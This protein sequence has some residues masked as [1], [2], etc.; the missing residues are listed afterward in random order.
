MWPDNEADIDLLGF[1]YLVDELEIVLTE[2]R[3]LPVTV[4]VAGEWGSG[5]SSLMRLARARLESAEYGGRYVCVSFSPWRHEDAEDIKAALIATVMDALAV[6]LKEAEVAQPIRDRLERLRSWAHSWALPKTMA[7]TGALLAG[8]D[9]EVAEVAGAAAQAVGSIPFEPAA[10]PSQA[11]PRSFE[12]VSQF[13]VEFARLME[14]LRGEIDALVVFVDDLDRCLTPAIVST[15]EAIRLFL[16]APRTA[17]VVGAHQRIIQ[18]ALD[19]RYPRAGDR[20]EA[21]GIDYL[22]KVLQVTIAIPPLAAPEAL[23]YINLLF[24]ELYAD[25]AQ[26]D[27]LLTEALRIRAGDQLAEAM[28]Y[29][30]AV[31]VLGELPEDLVEAFELVERIG[32]P[33]AGGA[34]G[35]PRQ[36]KRFLNTLLLRQRTAS[37]RGAPIRP[38]ILAKL[39]LLEERHVEE[40]ERIYQW[41]LAAAGAPVELALA[42]QLA[43][44]GQAGKAPAAVK[45]AAEE[46]MQRPGMEDWLRLEP[47]LVDIALGP[48]FSL[49]RDKLSTATP[50]MR[51]P[52]HIQ[53]LVVA[54]QASVDRDRDAAIAATSDLTPED[55][56]AFATALFGVAAREPNGNAMGGAAALAAARPEFADAFFTMLGEITP[57]RVPLT[58]PGVLRL[59]FKTDARLTQVLGVWAGGPA[60]LKA[61]IELIERS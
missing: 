24:A 1:G 35:N 33:L 13:H 34:R 12:S 52:S 44:G 43:K 14:E 46:F 20:G 56:A 8:L 15:F 16:Q 10:V 4:G 60:K 49:A 22:E 37:K 25:E 19:D 3:L 40:F 48:Y 39:M 58:L 61:A 57:T 26:F 23:T 28:N 6:H 36:L 27:L 29:G 47:A 50:V 38:G 17:Y 45:N 42:E 54:A 18:A 41:Q 32:P 11:V 55:R 21:L 9:P 7:S 2:P 51:L 5:K 59:R 53:E 30:I 31:G